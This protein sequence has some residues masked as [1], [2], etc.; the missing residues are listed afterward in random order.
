[1]PG[2]NPYASPQVVE[3]PPPV[4][5]SLGDGR[6]R[7]YGD[8][9]VIA[10]GAEFPDRCIYCSA[11]AARKRVQFRRFWMSIRDATIRFVHFEY[12]VCPQHLAVR[13]FR[14]MFSLA[15][16]GVWGSG[17]ALESIGLVRSFEWII[18]MLLIA[19]VWIVVERLPSF[20]LMGRI[21]LVVTRFRKR[22][23]WLRNTGQ[24]FLYSVDDNS[25]SV[26][27]RLLGATSRSRRC[28][29]LVARM[30]RRTSRGFA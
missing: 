18:L 5:V 23:I 24:P 22:Y 3:E 6:Y 11:P 7:R 8:Y 19:S 1:M 4:D 10:A 16:F 9:L 14:R 12:G 25:R 17:V 20:R 26:V 2:P 15:V 30:L 29:R 28:G 21:A 13:W 27:P